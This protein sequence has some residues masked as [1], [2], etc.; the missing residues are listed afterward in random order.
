MNPSRRILVAAI[1]SA[2]VT[3][4]CGQALA[5][6]E[7]DMSKVCVQ[8]ADGKRYV[9]PNRYV[10]KALA[11]EGVTD[12]ALDLTGGDV[13]KQTRL[14]AVRRSN[15]CGLHKDLCTEDTQ[16]KLTKVRDAT[17]RFLRFAAANPP[18]PH[19]S[20]AE[21]GTG[22][23]PIES[24][25]DGSMR[26]ACVGTMSPNSPTDFGLLA[27]RSKAEDLLVPTSKLKTLTPAVIGF[28][29]NAIAKT[30]TYSATAVLGV[31]LPFKNWDNGYWVR[32]YVYLKYNL[33]SVNATPTPAGNIN[34]LSAG[35]L[36]GVFVPYNEF[37][38]YPEFTKSLYDGSEVF[39]ATL[40]DYLE[41]PIPGIYKYAQLRDAVSILLQ[42]VVTISYFDVASAGSNAALAT[43][44]DYFRAGPGAELSLS[45]NPGTLLQQFSLNASYRYLHGFSGPQ[46]DLENF[47][48]S[49]SYAPF[50]NISGLSDPGS[51]FTITLKYVSGRDLTSLSRQDDLT[52]GLGYKF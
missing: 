23:S 24:F 16:P 52:I 2:L 26:V 43:T 31:Q 20:V 27:L 37:R 34:N 38:A 22:A 25:L 15:Y 29:H 10:A 49:I 3:V 40:T 8:A 18:L 30:D 9:D 14:E 12:F 47:V 48:G 5:E 21:N 39:N 4:V 6:A 1:S 11:D 44:P 17:R 28:D 33:K 45:G 46:R 36:L 7:P 19:Y 51:N 35:L 13:T 32:S 50:A 41:P 42:P